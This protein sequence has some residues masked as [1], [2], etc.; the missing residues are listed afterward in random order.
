VTFNDAVCTKPL[1]PS[2]L[3]TR[4]IQVADDNDYYFYYLFDLYPGGLDTAGDRQEE[5]PVQK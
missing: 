5:I 4:Y 3:Q 2:V 1:L